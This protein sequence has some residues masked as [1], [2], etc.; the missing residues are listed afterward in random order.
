MSKGTDGDYWKSQTLPSKLK[1]TLL[2]QYIPRFGGMTGSQAK[3]VVYLDGYAGEGRYE[4]GDA[5]SAE[6]AMQVAANH[7]SKNHLR[8]N[9]F[10]VEKKLDSATRLQ[11]VADTYRAKGVDA[12]V[13]HGNVA[14]ILD[15]VLTSA[16]G[17]PLFLFLDP[18][19]MT[20]PFDRLAQTLNRRRSTPRLWQPTEF[21]MNFSMDAVRRIGCNAASERGN[22]RTAERFDEVCGDTSWRN[23]FPRGAQRAPDAAERV[24]AEYAARLGKATDMFVHSIP[25]ARAPGHKPIYHL[26]FGTRSQYG[27]WFFGDAAAR[28]RDA[29]W[30][31]QEIREEHY[32]PDKL[33]S[34]AS[35]IR[36]DPKR[37]ADAAVPAIAG[38]LREL[39]ESRRQPIRLVDHT[40]NLA[41][42]VG[43]GGC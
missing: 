31:G 27:L 24:A 22:E 7:L 6:I 13:H 4:N 37:I 21:L 34:I 9:C 41:V 35:M 30:E 11:T 43:Y 3:Q 36:P 5:G 2:A 26:V 15:H 17:L 14:G 33:F 23:H 32:D 39:L 42:S 16:A 40:L 12:K 29:W 18:C 25:V 28:A 10:F 8:W 20:L 1:H 38:N 19:G